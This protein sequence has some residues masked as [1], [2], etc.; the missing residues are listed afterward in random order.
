MPEPFP[1]SS[2]G[3]VG[4]GGGE[5]TA[6]SAA[7]VPP[8]AAQ[9]SALTN[10]LPRYLHDLRNQSSTLSKLIAIPAAAAISLTLNEVTYRLVDNS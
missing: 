1:G 5:R 4:L 7:A 6:A 9:T 2:G 8:L 3:V 10:E